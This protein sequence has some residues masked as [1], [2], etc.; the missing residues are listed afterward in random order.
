MSNRPS[1]SQL[2]SLQ[3]EVD[4]A[5]LYNLMSANEK[6]EQLA[7]I[8]QKL[9]ET[10][11]RHAQHFLDKIAQNG[12]KKMEMPPPTWQAKAKG[13]LAQIFGNQLILPLL[14]NTEK[15]LAQNV[16]KARMEAGLGNSVETYAHVKVL[17]AI[18]EMGVNKDNATQYSKFEG[19]HNSVDGNALR[20][21]VLGANDGL[22]SNMS[23]VMGVAGAA[24]SNENILITGFAGLLA[25]AISMALGEWLSVQSSRELN[26]RQIEVE[27]EELENN[28]EEEKAELSLIYQA[29]GMSEAE[30]EAMAQRVLNSPDTALDTLVRE[31][32]GINPDDLG[33]SAWEAAYSSFLLFAIGAIIPVAPFLLISGQ[34]AI[35]A[36]LVASALGLFAIGAAITLLTGRSVWFSGMRQVVFGLLAAGV[37]YAIGH[38][39]G[40]SIG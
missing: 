13:K 18:Q 33:G 3:V 4:C 5:Y 36:S 26:I 17:N 29:K 32:L 40:V 8:F 27:K 23:L 31:E 28:P 11:Q 25:G 21:A 1:T 22:V 6:D 34:T 30:A 20:A 37:T 2:N 14:M 10:E 24:V 12:N 7:S 35:M 15:T 39:I 16:A 19:R 38:F 9:S